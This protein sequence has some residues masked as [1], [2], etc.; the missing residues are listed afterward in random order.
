LIAVLGDFGDY[1]EYTFL[2]GSTDFLKPEFFTKNKLH[3]LGTA[4]FRLHDSAKPFKLNFPDVPEK[5]LNPLFV[6]FI[7]N[8]LVT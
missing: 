4:T 5:T 1:P 2:I 3:G 8:K 6:E 7:E